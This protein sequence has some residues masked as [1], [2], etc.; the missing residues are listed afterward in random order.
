MRVN[1]LER[2]IRGVEGFDVEIIWPDETNVRGDYEGAKSY[3]WERAARESW[4]VA[5]WIRERFHHANPQF[6]V[7]VHDADGNP[8]SGR[9]TLRTVRDGY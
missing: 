8:V 7:R 2:R 9:N 5:E 4:T 1:N 3:R 6:D